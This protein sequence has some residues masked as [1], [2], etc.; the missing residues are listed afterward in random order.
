MKSAPWGEDDLFEGGQWGA[1]VGRGTSQ[2]IGTGDH[3]PREK[4]KIVCCKQQINVASRLLFCAFSATNRIQMRIEYE[5]IKRK[6]IKMDYLEPERKESRAS[7]PQSPEM[8]FMVGKS[9]SRSN[10]SSEL[11]K[12]TQL[13][14]KKK[15]SCNLEDTTNSSLFCSGKPTTAGDENTSARKL[16]VLNV[17]GKRFETFEDTLAR[18]PETLLGDPMKRKHF[19]NPRT[20]E[21]FFDRNRSAFNGI[22]YYYQSNGT[23]ECP[24]KVSES[25]FT[26]E[27]LF[28]GLGDDLLGL[29]DDETGMDHVEEVELPKNPILRKI[30]VVF[31]HPNSSLLAKIIAIFSVL[32]IL[33]SIVVFCIE[34]LPELDPNK[35]ESAKH[36]KQIELSWHVFNTFCNIWFTIEYLLRLMSSP[37]KLA[38][39]RSTINIIDLVS[40]LPYYLSIIL[41][42][43]G[44]I[45]VLRVIRV[46]RVIRIFKLTRHSR[47]LHILGSTIHA[48]L[49]EL[50]MLALFLFIGVILFSSAVYYAESQVHSK[51]FESIPHSFWWAVVTMTTVGYGD[52]T[53]TT[54][55]GKLVGAMCAISGVLV[56]ALP[57]PVIVS[58]FEHYYKEEQARQAR[59][60]EHQKRE[61][62]MKFETNVF[63]AIHTPNPSEDGGER[64]EKNIFTRIRRIS[65]L[66]RKISIP[67]TTPTES[68]GHASTPKEPAAKPLCAFSEDEKSAE[69][70]DSLAEVEEPLMINMSPN[71]SD[72]SDEN[73]ETRL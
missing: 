33:I 38:F 29:E 52:I 25:V 55:I 44:G 37:N 39:V 17:S 43:G 51:D 57:V 35:P 15:M 19:L 16:I 66:V 70:S 65:S 32:V 46:I 14:R 47:G 41:D 10:N 58:N 28:F 1:D 9:S 64:E 72:N 7:R 21:Y 62:N 53:P 6:P 59:L 42:R 56:I 73:S 23:L 24:L 68:N 40:I 31:E 34:T 67:P 63:A 13:A 26:K 71:T 49:H 27:V 18:F 61:S 69:Q 50:A 5:S 3:L 2:P 36:R 22:L 54:F 8:S 4:E 30:W 12:L 48:S 45:E 11:S 20:Q 60:E